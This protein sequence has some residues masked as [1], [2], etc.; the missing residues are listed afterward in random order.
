MRWE[1]LRELVSPTV[2][3]TNDPT[4]DNKDVNLSIQAVRLYCNSRAFVTITARL[5]RSQRPAWNF[6]S[7]LPLLLPPLSLSLSHI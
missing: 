2:V 7:Y 5:K 3:P 6:A 4:A 1:I